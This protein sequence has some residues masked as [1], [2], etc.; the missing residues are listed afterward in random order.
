MGKRHPFTLVYAPA[1]KE[2][3]NAIESKYHSLI[4]GTI[5]SQLQYDPEIETRNRK[6]LERPVSFGAEWELRL[7]PSNQFRVFYQVNGESR[8]VN[9]LAVG[10]KEGNRLLIAN[11]EIEQ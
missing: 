2:H 3:L 1:V 7:G 8:E 11:E 4:Q 5:E 6:P 9:V 10:I